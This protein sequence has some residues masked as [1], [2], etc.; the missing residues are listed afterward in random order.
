MRSFAREQK[1]EDKLYKDLKVLFGKSDTD[2]DSKITLAEIRKSVLTRKTK[3][4]QDVLA[5]IKGVN[6]EQR[7][8][9]EFDQLFT[10]MKNYCF[11]WE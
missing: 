9:F 11:N 5:A 8:Y 4:K 7:A 10:I 3:F 2:H 6:K 1:I